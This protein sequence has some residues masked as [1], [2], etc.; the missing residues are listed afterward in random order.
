MYRSLLTSISWLLLL[1]PLL[2]AENKSG[3]DKKQAWWKVVWRR[4]H[5]KT[6]HAATQDGNTS[7]GPPM[8][9]DEFLS[10]QEAETLLAKY[11]PLLR[12]SLHDKGQGN[13]QRQSQYRTSK[14]LR[15]PPMGDALVFEIEQR[16]AQFAGFD[17]SR[18]EDL[19]LACYGPDELYGLHRDDNDQN[20][21]HRAATVL[22]YLRAPAAGGSTLFTNRPLE[23]E[24]ELHNT[25]QRLRTEA[26]AL[27]LFRDYCT[28]PTKGPRRHRFAV[29]QPA[30][31]RAVTWR[32]WN[33]QGQFCKSSTHGAC[34]VVEGQK[35]VI[36]QW[37]TKAESQPLRQES[38][39]AIFLAG[40]DASFRKRLIDNGEAEKESSNH[41]VGPCLSDVTAH[42][43]DFVKLCL[44][45]QPASVS[46]VVH[47]TKRQS[48]LRYQDEGPYQ[49]TGSMSLVAEGAQGGLEAIYHLRG[50]NDWSLSFWAKN[51]G[52]GMVVAS[53]ESLFSIVVDDDP[54]DKAG[55]SSSFAQQK[56]TWNIFLGDKEN[57]AAT[58]M[59]ID[60]PRDEW[61]W[62]S[63]SVSSTSSESEEQA[64]HISVFSPNGQLIASLDQALPRKAKHDQNGECS[65]NQDEEA[66][67]TIRLLAPT[68]EPLASE[69]ITAFVGSPPKTEEEVTAF[70]PRTSSSSTA[71]GPSISFLLF[72]NQALEQDEIRRI[73]Y[74]IKR[75]DINT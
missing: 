61:F 75:Y 26:A 44:K 30:V 43:G 20:S 62:F 39:Q 21:A 55:D 51:V 45:E 68:S 60:C 67:F 12:E 5:N 29:V 71:T 16:A 49:G 42:Q 57:I 69:S 72:H 59:E 28:K 32:N 27:E 33:D 54:N 22:I 47:Q 18:V 15:L 7:C 53:I 46:Q 14:S 48:T 52:P 23:D 9:I 10:P 1:L 37:I 50:G 11:E 13:V 6:N 40:A 74:E 35:C 65:N 25:K 34:P 17:H 63:M 70:V 19:Q 66:K 8:V 4:L 31:G 24:R 3:D 58:S 73:R 41:V 56:Q 36:Q 64:L 2:L 38:V